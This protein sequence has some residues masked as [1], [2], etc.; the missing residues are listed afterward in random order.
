MKRELVSVI[1]LSTLFCCSH[2][3]WFSNAER[4]VKIADAQTLLVRIGGL[5][6]DSELFEPEAIHSMVAE[7]ADKEMKAGEIKV[8]FKRIRQKSISA[9][10]AQY[11]ER[12]GENLPM[13]V[14]FALDH[15][16][17]KIRSGYKAM[18][19]VVAVEKEK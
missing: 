12:Y 14:V 1:A 2:A 18:Y 7:I 8:Y 4:T 10:E 16:K 11:R 13:L 6:L 17:G 19:R 15:H 3:G 5:K 9:L